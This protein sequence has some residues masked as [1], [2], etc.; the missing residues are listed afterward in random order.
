MTERLY[1]RDSTLLEFTARVTGVEEIDDRYRVRLG[2]SAF[3]PTSGGQLFDTGELS[4]GRVIEVIEEGGE[5]LHVMERKPPFAVGDEVTG[6]IDLPRRR[7][8]MQKHTGQHILSRS[9]T[10]ICQA[11]TI[12]SRLGEEDCTVDVDRDFLSTDQ[13][14]EAESLANVVIFEN[15]PVSIEFV[16]YE[17]LREFPLR[18]IPEREEGPYRLIEVKGFDWSACGGTHCLSSGSVGIIKITGREKIRGNFRIHF[19]TGLMALGDYRWRHEQI[20][21]ISALFTRHGRESLAGVKNL[22]EDNNLLRRKVAELKRELLPTQAE[23]W[24]REAVEVGGC[25]VIA[26]DL[27]GEDLKDVKELALG[28][29]HRYSAVALIG[30][31]DKLLVAV[32][33]GL[34]HSASEIVQRAAA[35]LGGRGGGSPQ[36][37][38]GGGF[39]KDDLK[40]LLAAPEGFLVH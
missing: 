26:L 16:P 12:S 17:K 10:N 2:Q 28:I 18:K 23:K 7:D 19:L 27:S 35:R 40:E 39:A 11:T 30:V 32:S 21:H 4:G 37:A 29:I 5:I 24:F 15:R 9:L 8:N 36:L 22:I 6:K 38:Q 34:P 20:E 13:L 33:E 31:D 25:K 14:A 1:Y 3:Y